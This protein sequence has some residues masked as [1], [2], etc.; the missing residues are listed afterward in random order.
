[1]TRWPLSLIVL[2]PLVSNAELDRLALTVMDVPKALQK[3]GGKEEIRKVIVDRF[4][5]DRRAPKLGKGEDLTLPLFE[6]WVETK[7]ESPN[8]FPNAQIPKEMVALVPRMRI[9]TFP[10]PEPGS[11]MKPPPEIAFE[12]NSI[13]WGM[14]KECKDCLKK[15]V[16]AILDRFLNEFRGA[17]K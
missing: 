4:A 12:G 15:A 16:N 14:E 9:T 2:I 17:G 6:F 11:E 7:E 13:W 1:M 5:A 8:L 3:C 10:K